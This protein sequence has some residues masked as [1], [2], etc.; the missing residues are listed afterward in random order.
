[1]LPGTPLA[2]PAVGLGAAALAAAL[3]GLWLERRLER[4][5]R[6]WWVMSD[7]VR[8]MSHP[9]DHQALLD[10]GLSHAARLTGA[11]AGCLRL[12]NARDELHLASSLHV[13]DAYPAGFRSISP[14]ARA[15]FFRT[16]PVC[17]SGAGA[18]EDLAALVGGA[19]ASLFVSV[20]LLSEGRIY[21]YLVLAYGSRRELG[22][23]DLEA[24]RAIGT[25]LA[26]AIVNDRAYDRLTREARTDP[27]TGLSSRR[28]FDEHYRREVARASRYGRPVSLALVDV[29]GL[30]AINDRHGHVAGDRV[31]E[32]VGA[33]LRDVRGGDIAARLGGDEFVVLMPETSA[34]EA[35]AVARRI[36]ERLRR[37]NHEG[38]FPFPVRV[39][40]GIRQFTGFE[41]DLLAEA[42]AAMYAEKQGSRGRARVA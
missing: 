35:E 38:L 12:I 33:M 41:G 34:A 32:A 1:M 42:D 23:D 30:K 36:R 19:P 28:H 5:A 27:L 15:E 37:L 11:D 17:L 39:S 20:P 9:L 22:R 31:L 4:G 26:T 40:I 10:A 6:R 18:G 7:L 29:D 14:T 2:L 13:P 25:L 3:A 8:R 21:G 16:A 24:L